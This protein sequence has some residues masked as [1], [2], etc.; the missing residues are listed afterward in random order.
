MADDRDGKSGGDRNGGR[1]G[2]DDPET[3]HELI[4]RI[5]DAKARV[6]T[7]TKVPPRREDQLALQR[8]GQVL[9]DAGDR[10]RKDGDKITR[11]KQRLEEEKPPVVVPPKD[12]EG[13]MQ[14]YDITVRLAQSMTVKAT[15]PEA[16]VATAQQLVDI[17]T[18]AFS[19][20]LADP[21]A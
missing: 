7:L 4:D 12:G 11:L 19:A 14:S 6:K 21:E 10:I 15:S 20:A 17:T 8:V 2:D 16:A 5:E 18:L 13:E 1:R 3:R 9:G